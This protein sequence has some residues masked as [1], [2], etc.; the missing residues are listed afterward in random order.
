MRILC[1]QHV[2]TYW[3]FV[4]ISCS[5]LITKNTNAYSKWNNIMQ[6]LFKNISNKCFQK[7][8]NNLV[9]ITTNIFEFIEIKHIFMFTFGGLK[10]IKK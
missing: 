2:T 7:K 9:I 10:N 5:S 3:L 6:N 8:L 4:F 1:L